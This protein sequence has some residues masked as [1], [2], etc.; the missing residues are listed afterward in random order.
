MLL[1]DIIALNAGKTPDGVALIEGDREITFAHLH[2]RA[3]RLANALL[4]LASPGDRIAILAQNVVEYVECYYGVPAAGMALTFLN[5]RLHPKEWAW[6]LANAEASALIVEPSFLD[7]IR[8][9]LGEVP[10]LQHVI[11]L[12]GSADDG[13]VDYDDLVDAAPASAPPVAVDED[14]TAWLIYTSGTTGFPKGAMLTHRNL[15]T[16]VVESV[17]EYQPMP[18]ER[19]LLA[20]PLCHVAGYTVPVNHLRG[21][22]VV[23]MRAYEPEL[24]MQLVERHRITATGLAPTMLNFLLQHPKIDQ[25]DLSTL[26]NIGYGAA[27]MPVEV[28]KRAIDRFGPIVYSGFGMTELGGNVLTFTKEAHI[29]AIKGEEHLLASCGTP[30]CLADVKVVDDEMVECAPG[31][32]GEIVIRAEQVLKGYWRNEEGTQAAFADGWFRTGDMARRDEE[33]FFYIVD[34]RKDMIIT[35]GENVYSREVE[36]VVYTHPSVSEAAVIGLPDPA[37]GENVTAVV[38]LREGATATERD[39]I[40]VCADRLAGFKKPK[41]VVFVDEL[42]KNVSGKILKRELR[43]QLGPES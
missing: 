6:I 17:I 19:N 9:L 4:Q 2:E 30:M 13:T 26:R 34:R 16:A 25:F 43:D 14:D 31:V 8:P 23:L 7:Q 20:F 36:E 42:P 29:R 38:V 27:A 32:V 10:S 11:V 3:T 21:G 1:G 22:L 5:Y 40:A 37:W 12:R 28:L 39:I 18:D 33:G 35:G 15:V 41:R 24:F